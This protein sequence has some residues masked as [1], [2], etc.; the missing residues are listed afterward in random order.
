MRE[1]LTEKGAAASF[2]AA[3]QSIPGVPVEPEKYRKYNNSTGKE[4]HKTV[5]VMRNAGR[6]VK[7]AACFGTEEM[8]LNMKKII[9]KREMK[10]EVK[11]KGTKGILRIMPVLISLML[12]AC[13]VPVE[14]AAG[15]G[16]LSGQS[17]TAVQTA[18]CM[19]E[20]MKTLD[21]DLFNACTDNYIQTEYNWIGF[22]VRS[23]YRM[24]NELLQPVV[25]RGTRKKKYEF[26]H[27]LY[28]KML[29]NLTWE[30]LR[31]NEDQDHAGIVMEITNLD[32]NGVMG[33]YEM[34]LMDKM[35]AGE[36]TGLGAMVRELS[37][38]A[39]EDG[40]LLSLIESWDKEEMC[41]LE[42]TATAERRDG[43]WIIHLDDALLN[44]CM[45]NIN[46]GEY[47]EEVQQRI[48]ELEAQQN[49]KLDEWAKDF[50]DNVERW[51]D[52]LFGE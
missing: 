43:T 39:D 32:M 13:G 30:I 19:M 20:S 35:I 27:K 18:D 4:V 8:M 36:G 28:E 25:K 11:R 3:V 16:V 51:V 34:N 50:S 47:T 12:S 31:V 21:L 22:P 33:M 14:G 10:R 2:F 38:I 49:E 45:G 41:T 9:G 52:G 40:S 6:A 44:A 23:E 42:V 15:H 5:E 46:A 1:H 17:L 48:R 26:H 29:E 7:S 37:S 24:F